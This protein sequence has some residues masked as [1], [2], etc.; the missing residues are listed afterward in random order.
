MLVPLQLTMQAGYVPP[1]DWLP[2]VFE[3]QPLSTGWV[4]ERAAA[5]EVWLL[6][7]PHPPGHAQH[8]SAYAAAVVLSHSEL[9]SRTCA[10]ILAVQESGV[11]AALELVDSKVPHF[12]AY[13]DSGS[14]HSSGRVDPELQLPPVLEL[15]RQG[16]PVDKPYMC[17]LV[18]SRP[19]S[20]DGLPSEVLGTSSRL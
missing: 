16:L 9:N 7:A 3:V 2:W 14:R 1:L 10:G 12:V 20:Q 17:Y 15:A 18:Y 8:N 13:I 6:P 19:A 4:Q 11:A 5:G